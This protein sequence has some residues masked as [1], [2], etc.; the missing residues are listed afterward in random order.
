MANFLKGFA[1]TFG[2]QLERGIS[3]KQRLDDILSAQTRQDQ[4]LSD[5]IARQDQLLV[6]QRKYNEKIEG[7]KRER[8]T[9]QMEAEAAGMTGQQY[10]APSQ[11]SQA[12]Y[13]KGAAARALK[14]EAREETLK[15][16]SRQL[17]L[18]AAQTGGYLPGD[19]SGVVTAQPSDAAL[20]ARMGEA[21][22]EREDRMADEAARRAQDLKGTPTGADK[23]KATGARAVANNHARNS[24]IKE[25]FYEGIN[26]ETAHP[27]VLEDVNKRIG[28]VDKLTK[29]MTDSYYTAQ[30]VGQ[31]IATFREQRAEIEKLQKEGK[32]VPEVLLNDNIRLGDTLTYLHSTRPILPEGVSVL[33][34][35]APKRPTSPVM[36][37]VTGAHEIATLTESLVTGLNQL[38]TDLGEDRMKKAV[39]MIDDPLDKIRATLGVLSDSKDF[40][41]IQ[42]FKQKAQGIS[43]QI[44]KIRSGAAVTESEAERFLKEFADPNRENY[45]IALENA[46]AN[47]RA[48]A[49]V[50]LKT[51]QDAGFIFNKKLVDSIGAEVFTPTPEEPS[52]YQGLSSEEARQFDLLQKTDPAF[53]NPKMKELLELYKEKSGGK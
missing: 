5:Q 26:I 18:K 2:P 35:N 51:Q 13:A 50:A 33:M 7:Q 23:S 34:A 25:R 14:D 46:A 41:A 21:I 16:S 22:R 47:E 6:D 36:A 28:E 11:G 39:G 49:R 20:A 52:K 38:K 15:E 44:L 43:N 53:M 48:K 40:K 32:E 9:Q 24:D 3:R 29:K 37:E 12:F 42:A 31:D 19:P 17:Q 4:L 45:F 27:A 30:Q 10:A 1:Q 8:M